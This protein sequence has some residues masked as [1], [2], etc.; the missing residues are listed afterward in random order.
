MTA[1]AG[2]FRDPGGRIYSSGDRI[3][4]AVMP[5]SAAAYEAVRDAGLFRQL[6]DDGLLL[7]SDEIDPASWPQLSPPPSHVLEHPRKEL[8]AVDQQFETVAVTPGEH[9]TAHVSAP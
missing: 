7:A 2:S 5:S 1:D 3:L 4:G 9:R 6:A 8:R